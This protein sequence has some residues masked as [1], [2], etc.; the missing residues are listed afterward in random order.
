MYK[1]AFLFPAESLMEPFMCIINLQGRDS[2]I[3][4]VSQADLNMEV[5][6]FTEDILWNSYST[7]DT[8]GNAELKKESFSFFFDIIYKPTMF[9]ELHLHIG[10]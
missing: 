10:L 5:F 9:S 6:S 2:R 3:C 7:E 8:L 1:S 4:C